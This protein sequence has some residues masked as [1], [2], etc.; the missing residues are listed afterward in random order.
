MLADTE[1]LLALF[2]APELSVKERA[3]RILHVA[4]VAQARLDA[5]SLKQSNARP[6]RWRISHS[7]WQRIPARL[8]PWRW[9]ATPNWSKRS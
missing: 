9:H 2:P 7:Q 3:E 5:C 4:K 6:L 1:H 8:S